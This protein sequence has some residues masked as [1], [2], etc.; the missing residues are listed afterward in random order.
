MKNT[1]NIEC[2]RCGKGNMVWINE[3]TS[4]LCPKCGYQEHYTPCP[5]IDTDEL[6]VGDNHG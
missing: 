6:V 1:T 5:I 3:K 4:L 2:P